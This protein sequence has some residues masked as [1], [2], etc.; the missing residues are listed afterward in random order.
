MKVIVCATS[1]FAIPSLRAL[2][3]AG[4]EIVAVITQPDKPAGRKQEALPSLVKLWALEHG[5]KVFQPESLEIGNWKLEIPEIN[6][7]ASYGKLIPKWLI[8]APKFGSLNIHPSLLPKYRGPSPIQAAILNGDEQTGVTIIKLDQQLDHGP[9]VSQSIFNIP[10]SIFYKDLHDKLAN[11]GAELLIKTIPDYVSGKIKP[12]P[13]DHSKAT[14]TKIITK[15][16]ARID[17]SKPSEE[18]DRLIRAYSTWPV[19]W[20]M[21]DGK[22]LKIFQ[23]LPTPLPKL[24]HQGEETIPAFFPPLVGGIEGG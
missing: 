24:P 1:G 17:W 20:T 2:V 21:L 10:N 5:L 3:E 16:D 6:I 23:A 11:L 18:I 7:V 13:Q 22:R 19:A 4:Y 8:D 9:I 15:D 14:F 12:R